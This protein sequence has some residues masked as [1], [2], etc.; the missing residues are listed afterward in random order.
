MSHRR[1]VI[2]QIL[3]T[4]EKSLEE[5]ARGRTNNPIT[6]ECRGTLTHT[7]FVLR[8]VMQQTYISSSSTALQTSQC[9][10]W[11]SS[12]QFKL[13]SGESPFSPFLLCGF[14]RSYQENASENLNHRPHLTPPRKFLA[15]TSVRGWANSRA[16]VRLEGLGKLK[17]SLISSGHN[18]TTFRTIA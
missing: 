18:P 11:R 8:Y 6:A 17:Y 16:I 15:H 10:H 7:E 3:L 9:E 12:I 5:T 2:M 4:V 1:V 13:R 14:L